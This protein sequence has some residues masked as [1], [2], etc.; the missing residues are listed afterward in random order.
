VREARAGRLGAATVARPARPLL[1][2]CSCLS[3][4]TLST[5][6]F[7][8]PHTCTVVSAASASPP[9]SARRFMAPCTPAGATQLA[10]ARGFDSS[11]HRQ[12]QGSDRAATEAKFR[13]ACWPCCALGGGAHD[14]CH[15]SPSSRADG[16]VAPV[17]LQGQES[18]GWSLQGE[19]QQRSI[20]TLLQLTLMQGSAQA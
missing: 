14:A 9:A 4:L 6:P 1:A 17:E 15:R 19:S 12:G 2:S 16:Q 13:V 10:A 8:H 5:L 18:R 11:A 7:T 3:I 20:K